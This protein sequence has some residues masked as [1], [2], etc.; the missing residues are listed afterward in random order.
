MTTRRRPRKTITLDAE[1]IAYID[2]YATS[3]GGLDFSRAVEAIVRDHAAGLGAAVLADAVGSTDPSAH[4]QHLP[5]VVRKSS[6]W[7]SR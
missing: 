2:S 3:H 7:T 1:V 6:Q 5:N 4:T